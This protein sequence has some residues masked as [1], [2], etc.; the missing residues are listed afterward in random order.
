MTTA[1]LPLSAQAAWLGVGFFGQALFSMRFL[2]QWISSERQ[3]RSV[4]PLAFWFFSL[5]GGIVLLSY[6]IWRRDPVFIVGQAAGI[7]VYS[8]NLMLIR[9]K[10]LTDQAAGTNS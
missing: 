2:I 7:L 8:R 1:F 5:A 9:R 3:R 10:R 6:A 4:M